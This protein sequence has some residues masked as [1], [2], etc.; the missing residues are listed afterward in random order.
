MNRNDIKIDLGHIII[1]TVSIKTLSSKEF[2][3]I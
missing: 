3:L 2:C 1:K